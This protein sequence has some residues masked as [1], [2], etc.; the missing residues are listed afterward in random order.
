MWAPRPHSTRLNFSKKLNV[1]CSSWRSLRLPN[2]LQSGRMKSKMLFI[3]A[4]GSTPSPVST[5]P[6]TRTLPCWESRLRRLLLV[7]TSHLGISTCLLRK[8]AACKMQMALEQAIVNRTL[9]AQLWCHRIRPQ[10]ALTII[11]IFR[12]WGKQAQSLRLEKRQSPRRTKSPHKSL[13]LFCSTQW[14]IKKRRASSLGKL[15]KTTT[16]LVILYLIRLVLS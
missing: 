9:A 1:H 14:T 3:R 5:L 15:I 2:K 4:I 11:E 12:K 8:K 7:P 6:A 13:N 16:T 10:L